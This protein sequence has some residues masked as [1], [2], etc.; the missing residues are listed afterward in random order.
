MSANFKQTP[1]LAKLHLKMCLTHG[2]LCGEKADGCKACLAAANTV[3]MTTCKRGH[4]RPATEKRCKQC[5][6]D[7]RNAKR[8]Q[9][10]VDG[11]TL[12]DAQRKANKDAAES[13]AARRAGLGQLPLAV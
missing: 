8:T 11:P 1:G 7:R 12:T 4:S 5:D 6:K 9:T 2:K 13:R 3:P 10:D